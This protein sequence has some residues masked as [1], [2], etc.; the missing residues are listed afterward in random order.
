[1]IRFFHGIHRRR[2]DREFLSALSV[3][4]RGERRELSDVEIARLRHELRDCVEARGGEVSARDRAA[5]VGSSYLRFDDRGRRR[6]AA[7]VVEE[8]GIDVAAVVESASRAAA[9][10]DEAER[11]RVLD[12]LRDG[13]RPPWLK[14]FRQFNTL[15]SG[16]K[17]LVD[18][19]ADLM[20]FKA[21]DLSLE[22]LERDLR[23]L[24]TSWFD[25]GFLELR[26]IT[27]DSPASLL[28]RLA[29]SEAVHVVSGWSD[30]KNR[31]E[32]DR[33]FFALFHP[34]MP[35]EPLIFVEVALVCG[36]SGEIGPLL[37]PTAEV[38]DPGSADTAIFYSI[39]N[40]QP[41][42]SGVS[43]GGFLIKHV[44]EELSAEFPRLKRFATLSPIPGFRSWLDE[45]L[46]SRA[47]PFGAGDRD[48]LLALLQDG[49]EPAE[50]EPL[51][52]TLMRLCALYLLEAKRPNGAALDPVAHFHL[53]NGARIERLDWLADPSPEGLAA[54]LGM[55]VNYRYPLDEIESNHAQYVDN[56]AI[57]VARAVS[58]IARP[59]SPRVIV[60]RRGEWYVVDQGLSETA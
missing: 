51:R 47:W 36:L 12:E 48:A 60:V 33:R 1:M 5:Q 21:D 32:P 56:H 29:E 19:R 18:L 11:L 25:I 52:K 27:W 10:D 24:L 2:R 53:T 17:F 50:L 35:D 38:I 16:T 26:R 46:A 42:L 54:S 15:P 45:Q 7:L 22:P 40:A 57:A 43:F 55:M 13:L 34:R 39:S 20:R 49:F 44:V 8:L 37:D 41:G 28:E 31:L 58:T 6:F 14:L 4:D 3:G 23:R 9:T 30:L 59:G